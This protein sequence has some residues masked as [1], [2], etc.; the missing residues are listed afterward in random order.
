MMVD[1]AL[2]DERKGGDDV[3]DSDFGDF[4]IFYFINYISMSL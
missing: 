1:S 2:A 3:D 4:F